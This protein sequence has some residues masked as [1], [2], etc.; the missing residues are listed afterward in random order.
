MVG[1]AS[2][3]PY[4]IPLLVKA[5]SLARGWRR[6]GG[7]PGPGLLFPGLGD[8][9]NPGGAEQSEHT[10]HTDVPCLRSAGSAAGFTSCPVLG[11][12]PKGPRHHPERSSASP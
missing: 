6:R 9:R 4:V 11:I 12:T 10:A 2:S 7:L 8:V 5:T 3:F 1:R